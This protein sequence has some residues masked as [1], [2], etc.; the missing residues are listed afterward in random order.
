[1]E[2][3]ISVKLPVH[4]HTSLIPTG[5]TGPSAFLHLA[6]RKLEEM[7]KVEPGWLLLNWEDA[8]CPVA[9][10]LSSHLGIQILIPA[11]VSETIL[12]SHHRID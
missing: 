8:G 11:E 4:T 10:P 2:D 12:E 7:Q 6:A 1:M 9:E 3:K 5:C